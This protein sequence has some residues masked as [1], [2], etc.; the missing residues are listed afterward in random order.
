MNIRS[1]FVYSSLLFVLAIPSRL[2]AAA[3]VAQSCSGTSSGTTATCI[4]PG[5]VTAGSTIVV[6]ATGRLSA[7][8]ETITGIVHGADT[9]FALLKKSAF[10]GSI[11]ETE[12]WRMANVAD[13]STTLNI[14]YSGSRT[15]VVE[16]VE[17]TGVRLTSPADDPNSAVGSSATVTSG[18]VVA[19]DIDQAANIYVGCLGRT[20][21]GE[22]AP[23]FSG[24]TGSGLT[25]TEQKD[26]G[27]GGNSGAYMAIE[28]APS[29][30]AVDATV[31]ATATTS[32]N[33]GGVIGVFKELPP[34]STMTITPAGLGKGRVTTSPASLLSCGAVC[35]A[36]S[37][38]NSIVTLIAEPTFDSTFS[39]FSGVADCT[40]GGGGSGETVTLS[41]NVTC[42]ATFALK[43]T[44]LLTVNKAG[45]GTGLVRSS[46]REID[47]GVGCT[48]DTYTYIDGQIEWL[49]AYPDAGSY[50]AGFS[51]AGCPTTMVGG[52][53]TMSAARTCTATFNLQAAPAELFYVNV[54]GQDDTTKCTGLASAAYDGSGGPDACAFA[55]VGYAL[56][57]SRTNGFSCT[58][59][60]DIQVLTVGTL[61]EAITGPSV[62]QCPDYNDTLATGGP[63]IVQG[64]GVATIINPSGAAAAM[65]FG[66]SGGAS[67][68]RFLMVRDFRLKGGTSA[69]FR[70]ATGLYCTETVLVDMT[71][72][73]FG[74]FVGK[75]NPI[76]AAIQFD[77]SFGVTDGNIVDGAYIAGD[78]SSCNV[79]PTSPTTNGSRFCG[80]RY[81]NGIYAGGTRGIDIRNSEVRD[82]RGGAGRF[83]KNS[84]VQDSVFRNLWCEDEACDD[85]CFQNYD[86]DETIYRRLLLESVHPTTN[87]SYKTF[88][89]RITAGSSSFTAG[90]T[91]YNITFW[92][93]DT[94]CTGTT[95]A[96]LQNSWG[97]NL[98]RPAVAN[99]ADGGGAQGTGYD[100][101]NL[102]RNIFAN[103]TGDGSNSTAIY[104]DNFTNVNNTCPTASTWK[105]DLFFNVTDA[106]N[107]NGCASITLENDDL[108]E[109]MTTLDLDSSRRPNPWSPA[110]FPQ[111]TTYTA[112]DGDISDGW[113]GYSKGLCA[114]GATAPVRGQIIIVAL[115]TR[116]GYP[117]QE[118]GRY[119]IQP[120]E[121]LGFI[122]L[123]Q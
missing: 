121:A 51:G 79:Y 62:C 49:N 34:Q 27:T 64:A 104:T 57:T 122:E 31:T 25:W 45:T 28:T 96:C 95:A 35:A 105:G 91:L 109:V 14:T 82:L 54:G 66:N 123:G 119:T 118:V 15:R 88:R 81:A 107:A 117:P 18:I 90:M 70:C 84:I 3:A 73:D 55:S 93:E 33:F 72:T 71:F 110:C 1:A 13:T 7:S 60:D 111:G 97:A 102:A 106:T 116:S 10:Q 42:T 20:T 69:G 16:A 21:S 114:S 17:L 86:Q 68:T 87:T 59:G 36:N 67:R 65:T 74:L 53:I 61:T 103:I 38:T 24:Q 4:F 75:P 22:A 115:L 9:G 89:T 85:G 32:G 44:R 26:T 41:A 113:V 63:C 101:M 77:A 5:A 12:M 99:N 2:E 46:G 50:F 39:G 6:C 11:L 112:R 120:G 23:T 37:D 48:S 8:S 80:S 30:I 43:T 98:R 29:A 83:A 100:E 56:N 92:G 40:D 108:T 76:N 94:A 78:S 52:S 47:C 19:A 58:N